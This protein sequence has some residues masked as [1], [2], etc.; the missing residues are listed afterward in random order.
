MTTPTKAS[1]SAN[2]TDDLDAEFVVIYAEVAAKSEYVASGGKQLK[3]MGWSDILARLHGR[4]DLTTNSQLQLRWKRLTE[5]YADYT[6]LMLKFSGDGLSRFR[7][8]PFQH[9]DTTAEMVGD[10][11]TTGEFIR[12]MPVVQSDV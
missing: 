12:G 6:W 4:G 7:D 9:Y 5:V 1:K 10:A 2:W 3:S 11:I 8:R